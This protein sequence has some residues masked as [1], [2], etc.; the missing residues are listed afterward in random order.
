MKAAGRY[1]LCWQPRGQHRAYR[2]LQGLWAPAEAIRAA[3][4][5]AKDTAG[6]RAA[7]RQVSARSRAKREQRYEDQLRVAVLEFLDFARR[8]EDKAR[9]AARAHIRH[10]YTSYENKLDKLPLDACDE[11]DL[12]RENKGSA[13]QAVDDFL[14]QHRRR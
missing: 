14:D 8:T 1:W 7:N 5:R 2:R 11:D 6:K 13:H 10:R 12:N 4:Q 9:L 3:G